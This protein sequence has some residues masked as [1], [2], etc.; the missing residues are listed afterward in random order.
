MQKKTECQPICHKERKQNS[1]N[2]QRIVEYS[3]IESRVLVIQKRAMRMLGRLGA[4]RTL[5]TPADM[6]RR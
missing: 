1:D 5:W 2:T 3:L 6:P 4:Y